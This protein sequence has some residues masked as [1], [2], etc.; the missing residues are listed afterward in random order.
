M[1]QPPSATSNLP[2]SN[3]HLSPPADHHRSRPVMA[4][5]SESDL[6]EAIDQPN[7]TLSSPPH[8]LENGISN[9]YDQSDD[10]SSQ[11]EDAEG[12]EDAEF[13]VEYPPKI[14]VPPCDT[15]LSSQESSKLM[16]RKADFDE[17]DFI[18][19]DPELYGLRRSV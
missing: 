18:H 15:R 14:E 16:K 2:T 12:S 17:D 1:Y 10:T 8:H 11:E 4:S 6:S 13:D 19:K 7:V 3:G 5:D 9:D